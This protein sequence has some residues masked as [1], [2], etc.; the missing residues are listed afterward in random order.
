MMN[1]TAPATISRWRRRWQRWRRRRGP[2]SQS[3]RTAPASTS[4]GGQVGH[5]EL[6]GKLAPV[7]LDPLTL[8]MHLDAAVCGLPEDP[9]LIELATS[10]KGAQT[11]PRPPLVSQLEDEVPVMA[12]GVCT[13]CQ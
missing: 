7:E 3:T 8:T 11:V 4:N 13:Q 6:I 10:L 9:M 1:T 2:S 5:G 12:T